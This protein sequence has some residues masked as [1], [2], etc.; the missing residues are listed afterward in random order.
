MNMFDQWRAIVGSVDVRKHARGG[1]QFMAMFAAAK[2]LGYIGPL[3]LSQVMVP[4]EYGLLELALTISLFAIS[5]GSLGVFSAIPQLYLILKRSRINDLIVFHALIM[6]IPSLLGAILSALLAHNIVIT[7]TFNLVVQSAYQQAASTYCRILN[8]RLLIGWA[9]NI[10]ILVIS[11]IG[12]SLYLLFRSITLDDIAWVVAF[13]A[14]MATLLL[15]IVFVQIREPGIVER[16]VEA[17]G[18]GFFMMVNGIVMLIINSSL[19]LFIGFYLTVADV[20]IYSFCARITI[21]LLALH[22]LLT[23]AFFVA[24]YQLKMDKIERWLIIWIV[25]ISLAGFGLSVA[26][27]NLVGYINIVH[28]DRDMLHVLIPIVC[29]Q[30]LLMMIAALLEAAINREG[31]SAA[32]AKILFVLV[33]IF[34]LVA[35][36]LHERGELTLV[37]ICLL[38]NGLLLATIIAQLQLLKAKGLPTRR[39]LAVLSLPLLVM[40]LGV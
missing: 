16:E 40:I 17:I 24:I 30:T 2:V 15:C 1:L 27:Q 39:L 6:A 5:V 23:T 19:R 32:S 13:V 8:K 9:D 33:G 12:G 25:F 4:A 36:V 21:I 28:F 37:R 22:Q 34:M 26:V 14:V 10:N 31:A 35:A 11:L 29:C 18:L 38:F 3:G 7:L 20:A